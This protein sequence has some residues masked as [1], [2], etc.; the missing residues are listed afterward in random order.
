MSGTMEAE[1]Y[2]ST[3]FEQAPPEDGGPSWMT[4]TR[5][6][7][8]E[9][10]P[11]EPADTMRDAP[12]RPRADDDGDGDDGEPAERPLTVQ[13]QKYQDIIERR[14]AARA[15][16]EKALLEDQAIDPDGADP[17]PTDPTQARRPA[18]QPQPQ[19]PRQAP[20]FTTVK[21]RDQ[22]FQLT[23]DQVLQ[24]AELTEEQAA[25]IPWSNITKIARKA[26][27]TQDYFNEV[28]QL[29]SQI[30]QARYAQPQPGQPQPAQAQQPS[31]QPPAPSA[32]NPSDRQELVNQLVYGTPEEQSAALE[33]IERDAAARAAMYAQ[34]QLRQSMSQETVSQRALAAHKEVMTTVPEIASNPAMSE[35]FGWQAAQISKDRIIQALRS[36]PPEQQLMHAQRGFSEE[37]VA[38]MTDARAVGRLYLN[39]KSTRWPLPEPDVVFKQAADETL[40]V[41]GRAPVAQRAAQPRAA[42]PAPGP[43]RAARKAALPSIA[44]RA[45]APAPT[46]PARKT[47]SQVIAEMRGWYRK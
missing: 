19:E 18:P 26:L 47:R 35:M 46:A 8:P 20:E 29:H 16:R 7:A 30:S 6:K 41:F 36:L 28:K 12:P 13:E 31:S 17:L 1:V 2:D 23:R 25:S 22:E 37:R 4:P 27:A 10:A 21:I 3:N 11:E 34:D 5:S 15:E 24:A 42:A 9:A 38:A 33:R 44:P 39:M 43:D 45:T 40:K 32:S 14:K